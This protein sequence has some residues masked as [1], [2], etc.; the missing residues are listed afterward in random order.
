MIKSSGCPNEVER[1]HAWDSQKACGSSATGPCCFSEL[2][3]NPVTFNVTNTTCCYAF[4]TDGPLKCCGTNADT[5]GIIF[6]SVLGG[7]FITIII[8]VISGVC[9][10]CSKKQSDEGE[11]FTE[12]RSAKMDSDLIIVD[13]DSDTSIPLD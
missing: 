8:I 11:S 12:S 4:G 6:G 5:T 10:V 9:N 13:I 7:V 3:M 1:E 2:Y